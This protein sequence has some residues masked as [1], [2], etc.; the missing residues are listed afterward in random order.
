MVGFYINKPGGSYSREV[1]FNVIL[2]WTGAVWITD[3]PAGKL[4]LCC[5]RILYRS[6]TGMLFLCCL[7]WLTFCT[8]GNASRKSGALVR[9]VLV[10]LSWDFTMIIQLKLAR[11]DSNESTAAILISAIDDRS[12]ASTQAS[13]KGWSERDNAS[14]EPNIRVPHHRSGRGCV[15][16]ARG[17][18][19]AF[20]SLRWFVNSNTTAAIFCWRSEVSPAVRYYACASLVR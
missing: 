20:W 18:P 2:Q 15:Q 7:Y 5:A 16:Q 17:P 19:E 10:W 1:I 11:D 14:V 8:L 13:R 3:R 4:V 9:Q 12:A 6:R